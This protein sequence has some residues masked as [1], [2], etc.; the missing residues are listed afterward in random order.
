MLYCISRN[1]K[2]DPYCVLKVDNEI[3]SRTATVYKNLEPLWA[4]EYTL[5]MPYDFTDLSVSVYDED[6]VSGDDIIGTVSITKDIIKK[7]SDPRGLENWF[8]LQKADKD[9]EIQGEILLEYGIKPSD[10]S[11]QNY[12]FYIT[13]EE[14]RDLAPKDKDG[15]SDP[16]V[17]VQ[18]LDETRTTARQKK[19]RFPEWHE[20]FE[21]ALP[22]VYEYHEVVLTVYDKDRLRSDDFMGQLVERIL[23]NL[24]CYPCKNWLFI[25]YCCIHHHLYFDRG[26]IRLKIF[27]LEEI[28]LPLPAYQP[29][30]DVLTDAAKPHKKFGSIFWGVL[31]E[32]RQLDLN[33]TAGAL[34]RL[35]LSQDT[36]ISFLD[37][38]TKLDIDDTDDPHTLFR[39]NTLGTKA[40]DQFMKIVGM[41][42]LYETLYSTIDRI[43]NERKTVELDPHRVNS[44]RRR[45]SLHKESENDILQNSQDLL[46]HYMADVMEAIFNSVEQCP[47]KMRLV[48]RN[49][50]HRVKEKWPETEHQDCPYQAVVGFLFLR[51]FAPAILAPK[52]FGLQDHHPN[53][54]I[55]RTLTL[56]AKLT[57][58]IGNLTSFQVKEEWF[59]PL[60]PILKTYVVKIKDF[61]NKLVEVAAPDEEGSVILRH[62]V[63][64]KCRYHPKRLLRPF[65][66]K[67]RH[68][69]LTRKCLHY[70]KT[71][72]VDGNSKFLDVQTI[73]AVEKIDYGALGKSNVGQIIVKSKDGEQ[74]ILYFQAKDVNEVTNWISSLRKTCQY[75]K[76]RVSSYHPGVYKHDKWTCCH[77]QQTTAPGCNQTYHGVIIGDWQDPLDTAREAQII[78]S[79]FYHGLYKLQ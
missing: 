68:F 24:N 57:Q 1:G 30:I 2:S 58:L 34:V 10:S 51:F 15:Y 74:D 22:G 53:V 46:Q 59:Q 11:P 79:Q 31:N 26:K 72:A 67:K 6:R 78:T 14:G 62:G 20:R 64:Y 17:T 32:V 38:I 54:K 60:I 4:E 8:P 37:C 28:V 47:L 42:Y 13:I 75:N 41:P 63:L 21:F 23:V 48:F 69:W 50:T 33:E 44:V 71:A 66:F 49:L 43:F 56:L 70:S 55:S 27:L 29:I 65:V 36:A 77:K 52:L 39:G 35:Y 40:M 3:I 9:W 61:I 73:C 18:C 45:H 25:L 12:I 16:Y 5:H 76:C 7:L 19:T